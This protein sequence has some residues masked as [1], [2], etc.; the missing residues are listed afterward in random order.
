[1]PSAF[2]EKLIPKD[3]GRHALRRAARVAIVTPLVLLITSNL[4]WVSAGAVLSAFACIALMIF[5]DFGGPVRQ[6]FNSYIGVT[7][8]CVPILIIG[9]YAGERVLTAALTAAILALAI[10]LAGVLRGRV[11]ASQKVLLLAT[12]LALTSTDPQ[13]LWPGVVAWMFGGI[14]SA[15]ASATLWPDHSQRPMRN[16]LA[17]VLDDLADAGDARWAHG[18]TP[19][20]IAAADTRV[21]DAMKQ[22]HQLYDG[23][24]MR[25][26]GFTLPDR[27]LAELV[28]EVARLRYMQQWQQ[29]AEHRTPEL[30]DVARREC[31]V[32]SS[33]LRACAARLRRSDADAPLSS[34]ALMQ[35][36]ASNLD[37]LADWLAAHRDSEDAEYLREQIE[38]TFPLRISTLVAARITDLTIASDP[39]KGD[40]AAEPS[41]APGISESEMPTGWDR[42][43]AQMS[44]DSPWF[45]N[46]VR[47][48][49]ALG[50]SVGVAEIVNLQHPFWITLGTI[51]ALRFDALGTGRT[52]LQGFIGTS[53]GVGIAVLLV[54]TMGTDT[55]AWWAL[56]PIT[57]FLAAYTPGTYSFVTGQACF[58]LAVIALFSVVSVPTVGLAKARLVDVTIGLLISLFVSLAMWPRGVVDTLLQRMR[59]AMEAASDFYVAST[60]WMAG[61]AINDRL[62]AHFRQRST[63]ALS[64]AQESLDLSIAQRPPQALTLKR[65]TEMANTVRHVDFCARLMPQAAYQVTT[66]GESPVIPEPL[67]GPLLNGTNEVRSNLNRAADNWCAQQPDGAEQSFTTALPDYQPSPAVE[68]LRV[69]IDDFLEQSSTWH[70]QGADP[71]PVLVTWLADWAGLFDRSAEI[72]NR[73]A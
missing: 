60:D 66:R 33:T 5:A 39:Q 62:V 24:L 51:S 19:E 64:R 3:P 69:S 16:R 32:L 44:W 27:A 61:G 41:S 4:P 71:R 9:A 45:R 40:V 58:T 38:D 54:M 67:V 49:L 46:A 52:V 1:M 35:V 29:M 22:L 63:D 18:G 50:I 28:D 73:A 13:T 37:A 12:V 14:M 20:D 43:R 30:D 65:W 25:P 55:P 57:L 72:L 11:A 42:L 59:S 47:T 23:N 17:D 56:L 10:G 31:E 15:A 70:G 53:V 26:S 68:Q 48:A 2:I 8:L 6:R 36:R 21:D 7:L 34:E